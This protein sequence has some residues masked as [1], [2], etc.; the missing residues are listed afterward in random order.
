MFQFPGFAPPVAR[1]YRLMAMGCP[2]RV[3]ADQFVFANTRRFSQLVT[4][5]FASGSQ[6]IPRTLLVTFLIYENTNQYPQKIYKYNL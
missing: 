3:P 1:E 2:I 4:P 6:G 5:F